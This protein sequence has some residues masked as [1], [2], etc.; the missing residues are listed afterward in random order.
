MLIRCAGIILLITHS[1]QAN[2]SLLLRPTQRRLLDACATV[3]EHI[4]TDTTTSRFLGTDILV[5]AGAHIGAGLLSS[6]VGLGALAY[7]IHSFKRFL[8]YDAEQSIKR[9]KKE[10]SDINTEV[11]SDLRAENQRQLQH[12]RLHIN[13]LERR[14][15]EAMSQRVTQQK[16]FAR[17]IN[18][19]GAATQ[20]LKQEHRALSATTHSLQSEIASTAGTIGQAL[21]RYSR[22]TP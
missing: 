8:F 18:S 19:I 11:K 6:V 1:T 20:R 2:Q 5:G 16:E 17:Q 22:S 7:G 4:Q 14:L 10:L 15:K 9:L 21:T 13:E 12:T 3:P